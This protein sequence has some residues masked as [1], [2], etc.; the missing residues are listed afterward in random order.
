MNQHSSNY[1]NIHSCLANVVVAF[2]ELPD[3]LEEMF[4]TKNIEEYQWG[5]IH[6]HVFKSVPFSEVPLLKNLWER[7]VPTP[8][9]S[10]TLNVGILTHQTKSYKS[11]AGPVFRFITDLNRTIFSFDL[12]ETDN[13]FSENYDNFL[14]KDKYIEYSQRNP[15]K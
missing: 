10:R 11:I 13:I 4:G 7:R 5:K 12:G 3:I 2:K 8:G 9:N 15:F 6:Q 1:T 14:G